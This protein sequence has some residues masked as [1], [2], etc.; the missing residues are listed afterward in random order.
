[1][2]TLVLRAQSVIYVPRPTCLDPRYRYGIRTGSI[3]AA[4]HA[5]KR[6]SGETPAGY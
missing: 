3:S 6:P 1:V 4:Q 5:Q 2:V